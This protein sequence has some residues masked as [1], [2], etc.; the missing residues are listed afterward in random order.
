MDFVPFSP[1]NPPITPPINA[2]T[3]GTGIKACP[4]TIPAI[5]VP[6]VPTA[7]AVAWPNFLNFFGLL[8]A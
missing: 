2:P 5:E 1:I 3:T 7:L 6:A 4:I 8:V